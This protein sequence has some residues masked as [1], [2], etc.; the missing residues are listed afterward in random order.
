MGVGEEHLVEQQVEQEH[1][2]Q[3]EERAQEHARQLA[4]AAGEQRAAS[5]P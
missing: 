5:Q 2:R 4:V 1:A 3:L